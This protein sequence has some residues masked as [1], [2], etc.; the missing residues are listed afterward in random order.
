MKKNYFSAITALLMLL[1]TV[2][3][4][5]EEIASSANGTE[6]TVTLN[7]RIPVN[8]THSRSGAPTI[9]D[10]YKLRCILQPI[11]NNNNAAGNRLVEEVQTGQENV[12]FTFNAPEG[13]DGAMLWADYV[14]EEGDIKTADN[15]YVTTDL[16]NITYNTTVAAT[17]LFN[18]DAADA[19]FGHLLSGSTS[20][21]LER[22]FTKVTFKASANYADYTRIKVTE[23]PA[24]AGFNVLTG[25]TSSVASGI[26]S[27][28]LTISDEKWFSTYLFVGTDDAN[29]GESNDIAFT[30]SK[31][32]GESIS[33]I[34]PGESISLTRN[35]DVI[36]NV[37]PDENGDTEVTVTFPGGMTDPNKIGIGDYINSNGTFSKTYDA[38]K[39][40][41][42]V[43]ALAE[44]KA[45]NTDYGERKTAEA[46]AFALNNCAAKAKL[47]IKEGQQ[48]ET[49]F[50]A[51]LYTEGYGMEA[52]NKFI[53]KCTDDCPI[54]SEFTAWSNNNATSS[55]FLSS[56]YIPTPAQVRDFSG[57][58]LN[59][60][61]WT[62]HSSNVADLT[63]PAIDLKVSKAYT[64]A[65]GEET[66]FSGK[67][68]GSATNILT[69]VLTTSNK[70]AA[71]QINEGE[72]TLGGFAT[73]STGSYAL[74]P[75]I[76]V[77]SGIPSAE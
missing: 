77:F 9:P 27:N 30:L 43:F 41:A 61:G 33:L 42:I 64:R 19:F 67:E 17:E 51:A 68:D 50:E 44:G 22:P 70:I 40:I 21:E 5:Q 20:I 35:N 73:N 18:N 49:E 58:V 34:M 74:R 3:C 29:L 65:K 6:G 28:E 11:D 46:Y 57:L 26:A 62:L 48:G 55:D 37:S 52:H 16:K 8:N 31:D 2:S 4:S 53:A 36:A 10:G 59:T 24:P 39:A 47:A 69:C 1:F 25:E 13:Y 76:T 32:E 63:F 12:T 60:D 38:S 14:K 56:W 15:L 7:V 71:V 54:I 23:L 72:K 75:V 66:C 45:D